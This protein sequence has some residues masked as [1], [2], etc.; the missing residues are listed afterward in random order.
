MWEG[1][2]VRLA[3]ERPLAVKYIDLSIFESIVESGAAGESLNELTR[4]RFLEQL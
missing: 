4:D 1:G 2:G 3:V